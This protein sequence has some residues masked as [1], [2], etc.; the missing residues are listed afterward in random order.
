MPTSANITPPRDLSELFRRSTHRLRRTWTAK[1]APFELTPYQSRALN[2]LDQQRWETESSATAGLRLKDIAERMRIAPRSATEVIDQ[3]E[4]KKLVT[5]SAD[6]L[7]RRAT[8]VSLSDEGAALAQQV[9]SARR[10][11]TEEYFGRL[12]AQERAELARILGK[13]AGST[14]S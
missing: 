1:L 5:R 8:L 10:I 9:R 3:L 13:L 7:D 12:D 14:D 2:C 6:P 11:H 4:A